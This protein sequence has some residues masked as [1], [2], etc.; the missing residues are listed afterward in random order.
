MII[1]TSMITSPCMTVCA[2][3]AAVG[4]DVLKENVPFSASSETGNGQKTFLAAFW[5]G[6]VSNLA[7]EPINCNP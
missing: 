6:R 3:V 7:G 2:G 4:V 1:A 5:R